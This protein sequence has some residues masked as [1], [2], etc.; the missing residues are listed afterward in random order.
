MTC[1]QIAT[2]CSTLQHTATRICFRQ[3]RSKLRSRAISIIIIK[4][5]PFG[6]CDVCTSCAATRCNTLQHTAT[7]WESVM[8]APHVP[9]G[10]CDVCTS[11][12]ATH[13]NTGCH[14]ELGLVKKIDGVKIRDCAGNV[15]GF[16]G[17]S[18]PGTC[19]YVYIHLHI[20]TYEHL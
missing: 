6:K 2:H 7:H 3:T 18:C 17:S 20:H 16:S 9:F 12:A 14:S 10:K 4:L 1:K 11:C 13:C 15:G 8:Y 19:V 5:G